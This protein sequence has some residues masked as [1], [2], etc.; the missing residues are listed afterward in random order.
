MEKPATP[1]AA[2][3]RPATTFVQTDTN[4][5]REIVQRLTGPS[6]T[7]ASQEGSLDRIGI[8]KMKRP[9]VSLQERR[10][11]IRQKLQIVKPTIHLKPGSSTDQHSSL[12]KSIGNSD[13]ILSPLGT[14]TIHLKPGSS[15]DQH[16]SLSK[17][18]SNSDAILSPLGTPTSNFSKL[19]IIEQQN[20]EHTPAQFNSQEE[21]RAIK[22]RRFYLHP[23]PRSRPGFTEPELL[24]L[25]PLTSPQTSEGS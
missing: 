1:G 14:P 23:S 6:E 18:I 10:Q 17:S 22:E 25:F 13:A 5:F 9:T 3:S 7:D 4:T 20:R 12:S 8:T 11:S 24:N 2:V 15:T 21:E 19:S 16:S